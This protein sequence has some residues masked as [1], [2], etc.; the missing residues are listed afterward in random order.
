GETN[1][2]HFA[3]EDLNN[4]SQSRTD[5]ARVAK[6]KPE[7][8]K[9]PNLLLSEAIAGQK[10]MRTT[11]LQLS[12]DAPDQTVR[13]P[14]PDIGGGADNIAFLQGKGQPPAGGP[15]AVAQRV[16]TTF[17]IEEIDDGKG[18]PSLQLQYT[19]RVLLNFNGL[20]WPH[21]TIAT[22]CPV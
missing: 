13:P 6:L 1:L 18:H 20:S 21:V 15:N 12:S 11:V 3:E 5:R 19:Q 22:L 16:T 14:R 7:E 2:V 17:W 8:L 10:I 4:A 9:N